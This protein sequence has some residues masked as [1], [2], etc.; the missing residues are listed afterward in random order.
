LCDFKTKYKHN[1]HSH[2]DVIHMKRP[3]RKRQPGS[4]PSGAGGGKSLPDTAQ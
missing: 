3:S 4:S 2:I 1:L